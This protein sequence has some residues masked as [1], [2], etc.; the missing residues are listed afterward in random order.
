MFKKSTDKEGVE[1]ESM[2]EVS[3]TLRLCYIISVN[4][5][6]EKTRKMSDFLR[7]ISSLRLPCI[8]L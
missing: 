6:N 1:S 3:I 5:K 4:F 8:S 7:S 2:E